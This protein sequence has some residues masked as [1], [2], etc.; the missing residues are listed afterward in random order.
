MHRVE[1]LDAK[2]PLSR[3]WVQDPDSEEERRAGILLQQFVDVMKWWMGVRMEMEGIPYAII[4]PERADELAGRSHLLTEI[5]RFA[6]SLVTGPLDRMRQQWIMAGL[7]GG[8]AEQPSERRFIAPRKDGLAAIQPVRVGLWTSTASVAGASMWRAY[9][10]PWRNSVGYPM[11]WHTWEFLIDEHVKV[12]EIGSAAK[13]V[14]LVRA[15]PRRSD[16]CLCPDWAAV[17]RKFDAV[18][19][20]LPAVVA[21]A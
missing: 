3:K 9:M 13:W 5:N 15:Y 16:G 8:C 14:E 12:A 4:A 10:E 6:P 2:P 17:A 7:Y 1:Q 19:V 21:M 11:P 20:T 18:H